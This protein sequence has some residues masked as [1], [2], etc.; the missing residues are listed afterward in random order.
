MTL[1]SALG[2]VPRT[3][4]IKGSSTGFTPPPRGEPRRASRRRTPAPPLMPAED[5]EGAGSVGAGADAV[6][7]GAGAAGAGAD[8]AGADSAGT[9]AGAAEAAPDAAE[10]RRGAARR[11]TTASRA[12]SPS[13]PG[14]ARGSSCPSLAGRSSCLGTDRVT[15]AAAMPVVA[16]SPATYAPVV[17]PGLLFYRRSSERYAWLSAL[18]GAGIP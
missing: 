3:V 10:A 14:T 11:G 13:S 8:A 6:G 16:T 2:W 9:A 4:L 1:M 18:G 5:P 15:S 17:R 7:A 12:T